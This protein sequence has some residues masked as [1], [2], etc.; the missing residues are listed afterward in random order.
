MVAVSVIGLGKLGAPL[1]VVLAAAGNTVFGVDVSERTVQLVNEGKA[2][3]QETGLDELLQQV[4]G[5]LTATSD[6]ASAV[7]RT[8][9]TFV[10]VATPSEANGN[11]S[12]RFALPVMEAIGRVLAEKDSF[13]TVVL[14]ST[15]TPGATGG[16][17][18]EALERGSGKRAG[19]DFGLCYGPEF[20]ALGSVIRDLKNPDFVLI[21]ESDV[22][23]GDAVVSV[24]NSIVENTPQ[25][26]RMNHI[27]AEITKLAVNTFVTTKI[28]YANM[29]AQV[30]ERLPG[31][32]VDAVTAAL[33]MDTRIGAKYLKGGACYGGPCFPRDNRAF[34]ALATS[35][36]ADAKLARATDEQNESQVQW[37]A[38]DVAALV[39][40]GERVAVL[41]LAYKPW[42]NIAEESHGINLARAL[43]EAGHKV[44]AH[45]FAATDQAGHLLADVADQIELV[46]ELSPTLWGCRVAIVT[47]P[48]PQY[49]A[50]LT[51]LMERTDRPTV[52][53]CWRM[54]GSERA[55][56][57]YVPL[58]VGR[59]DEALLAGVGAAPASARA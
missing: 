13:H 28:S 8:D 44:I 22:R 29:L 36:G 20:I 56:L 58:G 50:V 57:R 7:S 23:A 19:I 26:A 55:D 52:F 33:G 42:T 2:P 6:L 40:P 41:G 12:L 49:H 38:R 35:V 10:V 24:Y 16:P 14:T 45:D 1:S 5:R 9:V 48:W 59:P 31:A 34:A 54:L 32:N 11:Y 51:D 46:E 17:I 3:V 30:C 4:D 43:A 25:I 53:D 47:T 37:V 21:G 39:G 18:R 15:V 27:N